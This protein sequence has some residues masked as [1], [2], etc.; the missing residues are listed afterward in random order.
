MKN[1]KLLFLASATVLFLGV[2]VFGHLNHKI[3]P[4]EAAAHQENY[5]P[6][7]YSGTYYDKLDTTGDDGLQGDFRKALSSLIF[8]DGWYIYGSSGDLFLYP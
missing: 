2:S 4:L 5:D 3:A 7:Y 6:Y 8:P 1:K